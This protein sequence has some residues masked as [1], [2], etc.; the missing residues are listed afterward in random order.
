MKDPV[1]PV[2]EPG[3]GVSA[4]GS[5]VPD[6]LFDR[7]VEINLRNAVDVKSV[8]NIRRLGGY[9]A[10]GG[11]TMVSGVLFRSSGLCGLTAEDAARLKQLGVSTVVDLRTEEEIQASPDINLQ[12][13]RR[14]FC[15]LPALNPSA[16]RDKLAQ[17]YMAAARA[18]EKAFYLSEY[19]AEVD[20]RRMYK[21]VLTDT[22][23]LASLRGVFSA[24]L[25]P[26][27][28]GIL[29]HC[30]SGKDRTGIV[31][32]LLMFALGVGREDIKLEYYASAVSLFSQSEQ[33]TQSLRSRG[34]SAALIDE[35]RYFSGIGVNIAEQV[36]AAIVAEYGTVR[37]F[38]CR[39]LWLD[40]DKILALRKKYLV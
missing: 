22:A 19:I 26:D 37:D 29:F 5:A 12:G 11:K 21:T 6:G 9:A 33:M 2:A 15:P 31:A 32:A 17:K 4:E 3:A 7:A 1:P 16:C 13:F 36:Y 35:T 40:N 27:S 8:V 34:Y 39:A 14:C 30:T 25:S 28:G 18:G 10:A 24:F 38:L 23:S 20:M